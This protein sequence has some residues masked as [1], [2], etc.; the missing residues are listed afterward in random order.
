MPQQ[1]QTKDIDGLRLV[2]GSLPPEKAGDILVA[3]AKEGFTD[4]CSDL[5]KIYKC[6]YVTG[7]PQAINAV[8][9]KNGLNPKQFPKSL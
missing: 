6:D 1:Y 5:K 3:W 2:R 4:A 7:S 8:R 9:Q